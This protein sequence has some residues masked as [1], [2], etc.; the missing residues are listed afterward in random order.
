[1]HRITVTFTIKLHHEYDDTFDS[2]DHLLEEAVVPPNE[3]PRRSTRTTRY[4]GN[5]LGLL[6]QKLSNDGPT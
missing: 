6:S 4:T 1:M 3:D 2:L 5:F